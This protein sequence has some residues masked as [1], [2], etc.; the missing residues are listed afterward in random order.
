MSSEIGL[1]PVTIVPWMCT[2]VAVEAAALVA[3]RIS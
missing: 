1:P 2:E 3:S